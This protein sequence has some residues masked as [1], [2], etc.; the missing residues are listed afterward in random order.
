MTFGGLVSATTGKLTSRLSRIQ[1]IGSR[2]S[3]SRYGCVS[4]RLAAFGVGSRGVDLTQG[5]IWVQLNQSAARRN[6]TLPPLLCLGAIARRRAKQE[7]GIL[8]GWR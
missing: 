8:G 2:A 1:T 5:R 7:R 3:A 6:E 4:H